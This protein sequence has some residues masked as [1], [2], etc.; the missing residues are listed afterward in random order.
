LKKILF[1]DDVHPFLKNNL[2]KEGFECEVDLHSS[3]LDFLEKLP[4]F[5]GL[6]C[7]SRF[8]IDEEVLL[9]AKN[10][11]FIA[12][13]GV[14]VEHIDLD[15]AEKQGIQILTSP[16]GSADSVAEQ[17]VG[18]LLNLMHHISKSQQEIRQGIWQRKANSA[19]ELKG[20]TVGILG[21]GNM[22]KAFAKKLSGFDCQVITFDKYKT[23]Y[24]DEFAE[25]VALET[26]F[27]ETDILS[28]NIFYETD[29]HH[30]ING[31]F[32]NIFSKNIRIINTSRGLNLKTD[33]LVAALKSGKVIAAALD[34]IE[35]EETSFNQFS[36]DDLPAEF[37]YLIAAPNV[38]L[39][40]HLAG[41]SDES[42]ENHARVLFEKI[43]AI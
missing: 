25:E 1:I 23:D 26:F 32:I 14:G 7:R 29:N 9:A 35:Y 30:F 28:V 37:D 5:F 11:K 6:I 31:K 40:P 42:Y 20:K 24:G 36:F 17:S 2:E 38:I 43:L 22:G 27:R 12:R 19:T 16:E 18:M 33:D 34:V 41:L 8:V 4:Q 15:F 10:L 13:A 39:T 21:Y 3:R